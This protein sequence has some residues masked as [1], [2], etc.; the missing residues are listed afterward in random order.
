MRFFMR[1]SISTSVILPLAMIHALSGCCT[2]PTPVGGEG[3]VPLPDPHEIVTVWNQRAERMDRLWG[4]VAVTF[5]FTDENGERRFEQGEGHFQRR[6]GSDLALSVGKLS[7]IMLWIGADESRYWLIERLDGNRVWFG[8]HEAYTRTKGQRL[9]LPVAPHELLMLMGIAP[10]PEDAE[11]AIAR[12][13]SGDLILTVGVTPES[14]APQG[15][16]RVT[17]D[18]V[19]RLPIN[20]ALLDRQGSPILLAEHMMVTPTIVRYQQSSAFDNIAQAIRIIYPR[21]DA[22]IAINFSDEISDSRRSGRLQDPAFDL[23]TLIDLL[24]PMDQIINLDA[25]PDSD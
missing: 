6:D 21:D 11:I 20:I 1:R 23:D 14:E 13:P 12:D 7:E 10:F 2:H 8:E 16:W 17:M 22:S 3:P 19:S 5:R 9:G 25:T 24:G 15:F 18:P 4:R